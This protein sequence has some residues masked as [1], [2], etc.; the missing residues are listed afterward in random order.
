MQG[1]PMYAEILPD[2]VP[3]LQ[4]HLQE[5]KIV[6]MKKIFIDKA[7]QLFKLVRAPYMIRLNKWTIIK[8]VDHELKDFPKYTFVL[9]PFSQ[10]PQL[11]NNFEY[12]VGMYH[13]ILYLE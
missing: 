5:N 2:A 11:E 7:K 12:F 4:S 6:I 8:Q 9:T 10:I 13:K 1:T 3:V